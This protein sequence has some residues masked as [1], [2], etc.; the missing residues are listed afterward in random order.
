MKK[1]HWIALA[2]A[3]A[4]GIAVCDGLRIRDKASVVVG[5][6][7][8]AA[9]IA[10]ADAKIKDALIAKQNTIIGQ[11]DKEIAEKIKI[12]GQKTNA[13]G[14]KDKEL[15]KIRGT[16]PKLS[17]DCRAKLLELDNTWAQ[18]FSLSEAIIAEKDKV[19]SA[20]AVKFN[21]QVVISESWKAKY[22]AECRLL[23]LATQGWKVAERKLR[24]TR[25]MSTVKSGLIVG[26]LG[27]IGYSAIKGK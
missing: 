19:I 25:V 6:Y 16:W 23:Q 15:D 12:I 5:R 26:T 27:Y 1:I 14:Q 10:E 4:F 21:A 3:I 8:E 20:W 13:I 11:K 18:K 2:L 17:A 9:A 22:D 7:Q 24:W